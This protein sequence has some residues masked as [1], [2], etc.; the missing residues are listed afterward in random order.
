L[1]AWSTILPRC[2]N[3]FIYRW[4]QNVRKK[5]ETGV[6]GNIY[7]GIQDFYE[8]SFALHFLK[9]NDVFADVGA[10]VG[11]YSIIISN[12]KKSN[13]FHLNLYHLRP[14]NYNKILN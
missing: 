4:F 1:A 10:N 13:H 2:K 3:Y 12:T 11:F 6:T 9:E 8:I 14:K 5:N 7:V